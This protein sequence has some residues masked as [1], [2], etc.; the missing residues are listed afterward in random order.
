MARALRLL[1][2]SAIY[3]FSVG[4]ACSL[5]FAALNLIKFPLLIC[6][7]VSVSAGAY[8]LVAR[9]FAP[10]LGFS[11][12]RRLVIGSYAD[13][14]EL[15]ASFAPVTLFLAATLRSPTSLVELGEYPAF[16]AGNVALI[17]LGGVLSVG[18]QAVALL[19][20]H[21]LPRAR[22]LSLVGGWLAV[23]LLV[24]G[25]G[26]WYLRPFF[27]NRA[28]VD[29]GSFCQGSRP[30]FRGAESFFEAVYQLAVPPAQDKAGER[31]PQR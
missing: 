15:L 4:A 12:V 18:R 1:L 17:A 13:L 30:D 27:G 23:S 14:A 28:V 29:D 24:G 22:A 2:A 5:R 10:H 3:G 16:L 8:Y 20:R 31:R 6:I 26:A 11:A 21:A 9:L 7:S 25:Q 19:E